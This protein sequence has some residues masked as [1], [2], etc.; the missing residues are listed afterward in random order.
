MQADGA[1]GSWAPCC[2]RL[3]LSLGSG[4]R[5]LGI[6]LLDL[7]SEKT[8]EVSISLIDLPHLKE[9]RCLHIRDANGD[10]LHLTETAISSAISR[11]SASVGTC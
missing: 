4:S 3:P 11:H 7:I 5:G 6:L 10:G 2:L 8:L 1:S 9:H